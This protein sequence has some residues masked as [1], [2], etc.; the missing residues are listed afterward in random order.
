MNTNGKEA[1]GSA[2]SPIVGDTATQKFWLMCRG[3]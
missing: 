3:G 2:T 1:S